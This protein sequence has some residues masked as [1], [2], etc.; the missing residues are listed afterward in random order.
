MKTTYVIVAIVAIVILI[1]AVAA[2][3]FLNQPS[4]TNQRHSIT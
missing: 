3:V 4:G 1:G 2:Y